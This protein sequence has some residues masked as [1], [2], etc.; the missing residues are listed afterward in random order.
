M[1]AHAGTENGFVPG[2]LLLCRKKLS[3][4]YADYHADMNSDVFEHWCE[5]KLLTNLPEKC[6]L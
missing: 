1:I 4:A 5:E 3:E 6:T 2:S